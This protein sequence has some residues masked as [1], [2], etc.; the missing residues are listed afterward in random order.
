MG[1]VAA[2][3]LSVAERLSATC[4]RVSRSSPWL[5]AVPVTFLSFLLT[6]YVPIFVNNIY[7][8]PIMLRLYDLP[9]FQ[10]DPFVQSLRHYSSGFWLLIPGI[11]N[12]A[13][14]KIFLAVFLFINHLGFFA[15]SIHL[16]KSLGYKENRQL[17]LFLV[18]LLCSSLS[19]GVTV[20]AGALM[21]N[22]FSH[23]ELAN[24][25]LLFGFS[26]ALRRRYVGAAVCTCIT[27]FLNA[28]M[29]VWMLPSLALSATYQLA[30][31]RLQWKSFARDC[32]LGSAIGSIF[33][34]APV[35]NIVRNPAFGEALNFSYRQFLWDFF[36]YHFYIQSLSLMQWVKLASL[37]LTLFLTVG[38]HG[39]KSRE[40]LAIS[41][42][43]LALLVI[44][45]IVPLFTDYP[46]IMDLH[47]IR[48]ALVIALLAPISVALVSTRWLLHPDS[49][50][51]AR[52]GPILTG[53]LIV[54][55]RF[56]ALV[57][58][59][60]LGD[61]LF[62]RKSALARFAAPNAIKTASWLA[63]A[64]CACS[65]PLRSYLAIGDSLDQTQKNAV[66]ERVG[67][68][69][70][71]ETPVGSVF[72]IKAFDC[73]ETG[74][75]Y[76]SRRRI[77]YTPMFGAAVMWSPSYYNVWNNRKFSTVDGTPMDLLANSRKSGVDYVVMGCTPSAGQAADYAD[78]GICAYNMKSASRTGYRADWAIRH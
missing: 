77:Y 45:S 31:G 72:L 27:F 9:Q 73:C 28:F 30:S 70:R 34:V 42:G 19:V 1:L 76:T 25:S 57:V 18:I 61:R 74:F 67:L 4:A 47:L 75:E 68:W 71:R 6:G 33:L 7:H 24:A 40:F 16:A 69:A 62:A 46:L 2:M 54:P 56:S 48:A 78:S 13:N 58:P 26:F 36:P 55:V 63:L 49:V 44:G 14:S 66:Y 32:V 52:L 50:L 5:L 35:L 51:H 41:I 15:A 10:G 21:L 3:S 65:V 60:L 39:E 12:V 22:Y 17:N 8:I 43:A 38:Q 11:G 37:V 23:S 29:A 20:G 59:L 64:L 53:L